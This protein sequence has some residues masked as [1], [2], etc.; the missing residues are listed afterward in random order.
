MKIVLAKELQSNLPIGTVKG[1]SLL[2]D[3]SIRPF[4]NYID[5]NIDMWKEANEGRN[6]GFLVAKFVSIILERVGDRSFALTEGKDSSPEQENQVLEMNYADVL[7]IYI[8]SRI[9]SVTEWI[10]VPYVCEKCSHSGIVKADLLNTEVKTLESVDELN[11]WYTLKKG[12]K[13]DNGNICKKIMLKPVPFKALI[14]PGAIE[15]A[16]GSI[17]YQMLRESV[18]KIEGSDGYIMSDDEMDRIEKIDMLSLDRQSNKIS[19]GPDVRTRFNCPKCKIRIIDAFNWSYD[20]FFDY[21]VPSEVV[22]S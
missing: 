11:Q 17:K 13:L 7:Y 18:V 20:N 22:I 14:L 19:A 15:G 10:N 12:I 5:R 1:K 16:V 2:K 3:F 9:H 8:Y 21:S 4:Y 6:P